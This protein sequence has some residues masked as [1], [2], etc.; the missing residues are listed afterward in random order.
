MRR[1]AVPAIRWLSQRRCRLGKLLPARLQLRHRFGAGSLAT[2]PAGKRDTVRPF[3]I[4]PADGR[5]CAHPR[6]AHLPLGFIQVALSLFLGL[7]SR[8]FRRR[9]LINIGL[10]L[11]VRLDDLRLAKDLHQ[12]SRCDRRRMAAS[13]KALS[14]RWRSSS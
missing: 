2:M 4:P 8:R 3:A 10:G 1:F 6:R 14:R 11:D 13:I 5:P 9:R 12:A 7:V